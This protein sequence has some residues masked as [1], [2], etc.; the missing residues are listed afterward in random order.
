[1]VT[2]EAV[3]PDRQVERRL[4]IVTAEVAI[5]L[6]LFKDVFTVARDI[7]GGRSETIQ[8]AFSEAKETVLE[9]MQSEAHDLG[10]NAIIAIDFKYSE[11]SSGRSMLLMVGVGTAVRLRSVDANTTTNE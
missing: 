8:N 10:A 11:I 6:N 3:L 1:M 5:G 7:V 4:G 2:T 9:E